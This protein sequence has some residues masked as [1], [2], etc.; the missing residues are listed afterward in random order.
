MHFLEKPS[1]LWITIVGLI[2][3]FAVAL[4]FLQSNEAANAQDIVDLK[5]DY[6]TINT[7]LDLL[8]QKLNDNAVTQAGMK[9]DIEYIKKAV[10]N[11][12][13]K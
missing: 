8:N 12:Q 2:V 9:T 7:K 13:G 11:D 3:A 4:A 10:I 5:V 1:N 6:A